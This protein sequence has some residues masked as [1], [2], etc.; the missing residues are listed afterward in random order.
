MRVL[1]LDPTTLVRNGLMRTHELTNIEVRVI[2][3]D[4]FSRMNKGSKKSTT[5]NI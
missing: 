4:L 5:S 3:G 1:M 2:G